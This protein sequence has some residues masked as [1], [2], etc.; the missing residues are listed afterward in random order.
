MTACQKIKREIEECGYEKD[1]FRQGEFA[2]GLPCPYSRYYESRAVAAY[3]ADGVIKEFIG[4]VGDKFVLFRV[5][6][7]SSPASDAP[8]VVEEPQ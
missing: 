5:G 4:R 2:T 8:H 7:V 6:A 3:P 1:E